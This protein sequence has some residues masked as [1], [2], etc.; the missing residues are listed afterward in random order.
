[1]GALRKPGLLLKDIKR[2][3]EERT[4]YKSKSSKN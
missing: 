3:S 1:M 2:L 4:S